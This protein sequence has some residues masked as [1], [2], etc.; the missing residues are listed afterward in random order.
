M[1]GEAQRGTFPPDIFALT[2][3]R[4]RGHALE[5]GR[6]LSLRLDLIHQLAISPH[7]PVSWLWI[8]PNI[9]GQ[10]LKREKAEFHRFHVDVGHSRGGFVLY[11]Q[12]L[13]VAAVISPAVTSV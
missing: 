6:E 12:V 10:P 7:R 1:G 8:P 4:L 13:S 3:L 9:A 2:C 11:S 5:A